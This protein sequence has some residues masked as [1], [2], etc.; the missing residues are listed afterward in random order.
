MLGCFQ[1]R[2]THDSLWVGPPATLLSRCR[3]PLCRPRVKP[4]CGTFGGSCK[5]GSC[6]RVCRA[7]GVNADAQG[8][9]GR[10]RSC[11]PQRCP[12]TFAGHQQPHTPSCS[13]RGFRHENHQRLAVTKVDVCWTTGKKAQVPRPN[14][15][16]GSR[17]GGGGA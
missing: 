5:R 4:R 16:G 1:S 10:G 2:R 13:H 17:G 15:R 14:I 9:S 6:S 7:R 3:S 11:P 8:P 12:V